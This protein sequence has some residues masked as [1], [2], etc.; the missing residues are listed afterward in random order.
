MTDLTVLQDAVSPFGLSASSLLDS[1][2]ASQVLRKNTA[3]ASQR[4]AFGVPRWVAGWTNNEIGL[5]LIIVFMFQGSFT[6]E[7]IDCFSLRGL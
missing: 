1:P 7:R 4:G 6:L 5:F 2:A 3:E